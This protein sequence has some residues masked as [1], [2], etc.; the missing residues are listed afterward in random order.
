MKRK[1]A[2]FLLAFLSWSPAGAQNTPHSIGGH[3]HQV[4]PL[5]DGEV[6]KARGQSYQILSGDPT[7]PGEPFVIRIHNY[8]NQIVP[9]HWHPEDE[10]I[11]LIKGRWFIAEGDRFDRSLLREL[12]VGDYVSMPKGMR[13]FGWS[14]TESVVQVHGIGPFKINLADPWMR[15]DDPKAAAS[16]RFKQGQRVRSAAGVGIVRFGVR[17]DRNKITQYAVETD[18]GRV[19]YAFDEELAPQ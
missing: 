12:A 16:F 2:G 11:V 14:K 1:L 15:L 3:S 10:H 13:H 17:S 4:I 8:E 9:P 6:L 7:K 18:Q 5:I 19:F